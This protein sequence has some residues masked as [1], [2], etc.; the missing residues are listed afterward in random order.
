ML[1]AS[2]SNRDF[3]EGFYASGDGLSLYYRQ[4][5]TRTALSSTAC[6][7]LPVLCLAG[8][9]RNHRD[10][11]PLINRAEFKARWVLTDLRG[12]GNSDY[13]PNT[14]NYNPLTYVGDVLH[15]LDFLQLD[16]VDIVG[17]SL[18]GIL[19]ML[20]SE[21][22]P[23]RVRRIVLNDIGALVEESAVQAIGTYLRDVKGQRSWQNVVEALKQVH[24]DFF[25]DLA[26]QDW[27]NF[28]HRLYRQHSSND[29]RPDYDPQ[30]FSNFA[31]Q[32]LDLWPLYNALVGKPVLL[33]RGANS[34]LLPQP[35]LE[36]MQLA[37]PNLQTAI[38]PNRGH[39]PFL[40]EPASLQA[41]RNFLA[42]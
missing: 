1:A 13:D 14:T 15:L 11:L 38:V 24:G 42:K 6:A 26:E 5:E 23:D 29:L 34:A 20:I 35:I 12:R 27:L 39:A 41:I 30:L 10:F 8:I 25:T 3:D 37:H 19:A 4:Y 33:I 16:R 9:S 2:A 21:Q 22:A 28:A 7:S 31:A 18:G 40:D 36:A 32:R 17:T